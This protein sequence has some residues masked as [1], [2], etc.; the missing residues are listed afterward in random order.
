MFMLKCLVLLQNLPIVTHYWCQVS[1]LFCFISKATK[2]LKLLTFPTI[3]V[4]T[5]QT[6]FVKLLVLSQTKI[7]PTYDF[8]FLECRCRCFMLC[9]EMMANNKEVNGPRT[10]IRYERRTFVLVSSWTISL[11]H[12]ADHD[13][14]MD[15]ELSWAHMWQWHC[16]ELLWPYQSVNSNHYGSDTTI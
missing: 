15:P 6:S 8:L 7:N 13:G 5:S 4:G 1:H 12:S 9:A 14:P 11:A 10:A 2:N 16:D 3:T